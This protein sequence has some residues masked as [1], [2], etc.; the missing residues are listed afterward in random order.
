MCCFHCRGTSPARRTNRS[1][2]CPFS[3]IPFN[4]LGG[5]MG[6]TKERF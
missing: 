4:G 2:V 3:P 5:G 1:S 6:Q